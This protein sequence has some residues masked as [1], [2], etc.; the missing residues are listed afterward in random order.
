MK[1]YKGYYIDGVI[2]STK[3][4]IDN[5]IKSEIIRKICIFHRMLF[6]MPGRYTDD[7]KIAIC[8]EIHDREI[9]L[10]DEYG[11]SWEEIEEI[12]YNTI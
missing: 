4:D 11:M 5:F 2:F 7:E 3:K 12:P 6:D 10:H 8:G 9:R 1:R